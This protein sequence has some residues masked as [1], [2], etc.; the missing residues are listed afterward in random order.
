MGVMGVLKEREWVADERELVWPPLLLF[1]PT[2]PV[3]PPGC[4]LLML[5][6]L[7]PTARL[8]DWIPK[9]SW[10]EKSGSDGLGA[11]TVWNAGMD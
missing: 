5:Q 4:D 2:C 6:F 8:N 10:R 1:P 3:T 11:G 7:S 9:S